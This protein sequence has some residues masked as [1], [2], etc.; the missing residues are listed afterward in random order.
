[1]GLLDEWKMFVSDLNTPASKS[2]AGIMIAFAGTLFAGGA[3]LVRALAAPCLAPG[4]AL[5]VCRGDVQEG[6]LWAVFTT[7]AGF[8]GISHLDY[9]VKRKTQFRKEG[10]M[11]NEEAATDNSTE[12]RVDATEGGAVNVSSAPPSGGGN[13]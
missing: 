3:M 6:V 1:M 5:I 7:A 12:V 13:G 2:V 10:E 4:G 11:P 8:A 9:R